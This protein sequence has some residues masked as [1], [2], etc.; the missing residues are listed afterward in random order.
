MSNEYPVEL[1]NKKSAPKDFR[2][3]SFTDDQKRAI[4]GLIEFINAPFDEGKYIYGLIGPGGVGKTF[5]IKYVINN[6][7]YAPSII[8]CTA[9]T[10][11]ACRVFSQAIGS[12]EVFTIQSTFGFRLN[13]NLADFDY[14]N[15]QFDPAASPKLENI[16]LL[17]IDE[18]SMLNAGLVQYI[19]NVCRKKQIK[20]VY[21]G[22]TYIAEYKF[23]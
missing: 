18:S 9:P 6:C 14:K 11:K 13:L 5:S 10:H 4:D 17:I 22:K 7:K 19:N 23:F 21:L 12:R 16:S 8:R 20:I 2:G 1:A 15:P 3:I